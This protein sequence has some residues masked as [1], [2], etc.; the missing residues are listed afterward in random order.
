[1]FKSGKPSVF[2]L[3]GMFFMSMLLVLFQCTKSDDPLFDQYKTSELEANIDYPGIKKAGNE[4]EALLLQGDVTAINEN[5][6][7]DVQSVY[8]QQQALYTSEEL[9]VIAN[10]FKKRELTFATEDFAEYSYKID[11]AEYTLTLGQVEE[12]VWKIIRY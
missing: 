9:E 6:V 3:Y 1:M 7:D 11:G 12:G 5:L 8:N 10:A 2:F 4:T